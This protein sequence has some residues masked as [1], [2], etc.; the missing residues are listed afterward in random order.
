MG[1]FSNGAVPPTARP[2][3]IEVGQIVNT[4]GVHGEVKVQPWDMTAEFFCGLKTFYLDGVPFRPL[5]KRVQNHMV[6]M[7]LPELDD[8][9]EA[10]KLKTK[11]LSIRR[12][13]V[14]LK[15]GEYFDAELVGMT[16]HEQFI[17]RYVG[18]VDE[19]MTYPAH[20]LL[21]VKG[22]EH[23]YLIPLVQDV[24]IVNIDEGR[25]EISVHMI[26]GLETNED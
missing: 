26:E 6:I 4:H 14:T 2:D 24:F 20:K 23:T 15:R 22:P 8:M 3:F 1:L 7:K 9:D 5:S 13:E 25:R 10:A 18:I 21:K 12:S 17:H 19:V 11:V 16:V